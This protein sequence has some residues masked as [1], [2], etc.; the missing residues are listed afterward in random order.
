MFERTTSMPT[1]RPLVSVTSSR[2]EIPGAKTRSSVSRS[3]RTSPAVVGHGDD[4]VVAALERLD[5]DDSLGILAGG[6]TFLGGLDGVIERVAHGV[7]QRVDE[8][9]DDQLV[10]LGVRS[11]DV[12][13][14]VLVELA[15]QAAQNARDLV[16]DLAQGNHPD[17]E[18]RGL[19][20]LEP[21]IQRLVDLGQVVSDSGGLGVVE[22]PLNDVADGAALDDELTDQVHQLVELPDVDA[23]GVADRLQGL[24]A[25]ALGRDI[26]AGRLRLSLGLLF[27]R[28][29]DRGRRIGF[30][31]VLAPQHR[32]H[33]GA[34]EIETR[35]E[36][37]HR[38]V[39]G[40]EQREPD[41]GFGSLAR[42]REGG[43]H[44][45]DLANRGAELREP[46]LEGNDLEGRFDEHDVPS[47]LDVLAQ[48]MFL[49]L[50]ESAQQRRFEIQRVELV[51]FGGGLP[52]CEFDLLGEDLDPFARLGER[53]RVAHV[54]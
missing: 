23:N 37:A 44:L 49:V 15:P 53:V 7:H 43:K 32:T 6:T 9:F 51:G 8:L 24:N 4:D 39:G 34:R 1:P 22:K 41:L 31:R 52:A 12:Q 25:L 27:G 40:R 36:L 18:D 3:L 35:G 2:L 42:R 16:E 38:E 30:T 46:L 26:V 29:P 20:A 14:D 17:V 48:A 33:A 45:A 10:Q 19:Q 54:L 21:A 28:G 5:P 50:G 47:A 11:T 13:A